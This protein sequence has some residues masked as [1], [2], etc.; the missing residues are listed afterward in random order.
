MQH[1]LD[2]GSLDAS[3]DKQKG[4]PGSTLKTK[5]Q[6]GTEAGRYAA[7]I[8]ISSQQYRKERNSWKQQNRDSHLAELGKKGPDEKLQLFPLLF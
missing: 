8:S 6:S 1:S 3:S 4:V 7:G 2:W 5:E